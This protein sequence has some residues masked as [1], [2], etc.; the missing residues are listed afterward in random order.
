MN[1]ADL[2]DA[3]SRT[4]LREG[5]FE[6]ML[7]GT[8]FL[9]RYPQYAGVLARMDP[10]ATRTVTCMA[11]GLRRFDDPRS[12]LQ[13]LVN[14]EW[15]TA[16]P[17]HVDGVL[18]HE[19]Q[20][21]LLG[22]LTD[23]KFHS[24]A[25][26]RLMELAMELSADEPIAELLPENGLEMHRF[27][28]FGIEPGQSTMQRYRLLAIAYEEGRLH[29]EDWWFG[30][31]RDSHRP[32][33]GGCRSAGIG[34]LLDARSDGAT[35]RNWHRNRWGLGA[36]TSADELERMK[37]KIA[38]HLRGQRGGAD[39]PQGGTQRRVAK[40]LERV[41]HDAPFGPE[42]D[43]RSALRQAFPDR[44]RVRPDYLR[45]NR[46]FPARVGEIPGRVR[47][48]PRPM[49]LAAIDTSGSMTGELLDRIAHEV[50]RLARHAR[51]TIVEC[52]AAV[53]RVYPLGA[54]L[55]PIVGGGDTDFAPVFDE[56][57]GAH[58]Y[59]GVVY[60]TDGKGNMPPIPPAV[61]TLWVLTNEDPFLPDFGSIV[62]LP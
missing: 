40:T 43:W 52:D 42:I 45:P 8:G 59:Q 1:A 53:H 38:E 48:P 36:P 57:R 7:A 41:V 16:N 24:V 47:R 25:Y 14:L 2:P 6:R 23:W 15:A 49:L 50:G 10:L 55:G 17:E 58:P 46:R 27:A 31:M 12:R 51:L 35:E 33:Q 5:W 26:P 11:V 37:R 54:R 29:I 39:D 21:V 61:P 13:L 28:E 3:A 18:L 4:A 34:D 30:R 56:L 22:H 32:R 9:R 20:H 19:I 62:R 44:R 60:F